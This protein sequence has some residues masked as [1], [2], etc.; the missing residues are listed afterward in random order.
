MCDSHS[1]SYEENWKKPNKRVKLIV[2][3]RLRRQG[4][5][6]SNVLKTERQTSTEAIRTQLKRRNP[7]SCSPRKKANILRPHTNHE[8]VKLFKDL[9]NVKST[10][11]TQ[12][13]KTIQGPLPNSVQVEELCQPPTTEERRERSS[14][15]K[16]PLDWSLKTRVR[17]T[18]RQPFNWCSKLLGCQEA[19]GICNFVQCRG[20]TNQAALN[21]A[22]FQ[23]NIMYWVHPVLPWLSLFPRLSSEINSASRALPV[24]KNDDVLEAL[25]TAWL[26][27][28]RSLFNLLRCGH[29]DYFYLCSFQFA[30]LFRGAK[31]GG[32]PVTSVLITPT[33]KGIREAFDKEGKCNNCFKYYQRRWNVIIF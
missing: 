14:T 21:S 20:D 3:K 26:G 19:E 22:H 30:M 10:S 13:I 17:F 32:L 29:C 24:I 1:H 5:T 7:F 4:N 15:K 11:H 9:D 23:Q 8:N 28:F 31:I 16:L 12:Q 6:F 33:T 27:S 2:N 18:S 25:K